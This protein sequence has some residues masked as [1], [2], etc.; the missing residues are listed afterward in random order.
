VPG[1]LYPGKER[2]KDTSFSRAR[3][4]TPGPAG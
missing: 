2:G 3:Q 4:R 1:T